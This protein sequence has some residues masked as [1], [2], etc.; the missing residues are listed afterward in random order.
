M[1]MKKFC[2]AV[3]FAVLVPALP[4]LFVSVAA[5]QEALPVV[6]LSRFAQY[7]GRYAVSFPITRANEPQ[8][9]TRAP[10]SVSADIGGACY[11]VF[12]VDVR[13]IVSTEK[14]FDDLEANAQRSNH[15]HIV[16]QATISLRSFPGREVELEDRNGWHRICRDYLV[17]TRFYSI[18]AE[19]RDRK[20]NRQMA[21]EF[22]DSFALLEGNAPPRTVMPAPSPAPSADPA[23]SA[24]ITPPLEPANPAVPQPTNPQAVDRRYVNGAGR[25]FIDLPAAPSESTAQSDPNGPQM[26]SIGLVMQGVA[27]FVSYFQMPARQLDWARTQE[28]PQVALFSLWKADIVQNVH[29]TV[30]YERTVQIAGRTGCEAEFILPDGTHHVARMLVV[31]HQCYHIVVAGRQVTGDNPLV[32]ECLDSFGIID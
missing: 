12:C 31:G 14:L 30:S 28:K 22:L 29:G 8:I 27:Y 13:D 21:I 32:R 10:M 17:G 9:R 19:A 20:L 18:V 16:R 6:A 4:A 2:K 23:P 26:H 7:Q 15:G 11:A 1:L 25:Y 5:A 24:G 3:L